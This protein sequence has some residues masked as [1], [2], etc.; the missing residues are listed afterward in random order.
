MTIFEKA[1][2]LG[3]MLSET[4]QGKKLADAKYIFDGNEQAQKLF[5]EYQQKRNEIREKAKNN[6]LTGEEKEVF[7]KMTNEV[8]ENAIIMELLIAEN[9]FSEFMAMVLDLVKATADGEMPEATSLGCTG[10]CSS[11]GGCH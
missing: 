4:T 10:N 6:T 11:C 7:D 1:R 2:E 8:Q 9:E 5:F 3:I